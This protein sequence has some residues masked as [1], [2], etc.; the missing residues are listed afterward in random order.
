M[1]SGAR[2]AVT[3]G[4][5]AFGPHAKTVLAAGADTVLTSITTRDELEMI[6]RL[7]LSELKL[8]PDEQKAAQAFQRSRHSACRMCASCSNACPQGMP[9]NDL[10]RIRMY[11]DEYGWSEHARTEFQL[12][13]VKPEQW[14]TKCGDCTVCS[15]VCPVGMAH[16]R[17]VRRVASLFA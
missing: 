17:E 16:A 1:K 3:Q 4:Y 6:R 8:S 5:K 11:H 13:K 7:D 15:Q 2:Q 9:I 10:M 14:F 12:L